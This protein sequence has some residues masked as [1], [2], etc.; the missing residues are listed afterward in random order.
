MTKK[1]GT[2]KRE[3][4][5]P[6]PSEGGDVPGGIRNAGCWEDKRMKT[7]GL[8]GACL[9]LMGKGLE[10][11]KYALSHFICLLTK[12][13]KAGFVGINIVIE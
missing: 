8:K 7:L 12:P 1:G 9:F 10:F 3:A 6:S 2:K 4:A 11:K 13:Q 5:S